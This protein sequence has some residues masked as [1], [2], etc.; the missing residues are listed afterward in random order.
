MMQHKFEKSVKYID[1]INIKGAVFKRQRIRVIPD[2][3]IE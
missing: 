1:F 3:S 2:L